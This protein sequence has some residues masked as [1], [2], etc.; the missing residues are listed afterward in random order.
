MISGLILQIIQT[1]AIIST[2]AI[3]LSL[4]LDTS[5]KELTFF[6]ER[7]WLFFRSLLSVVVIVP[8]IVMLVIF[9]VDPERAT[10][11][12]L[13]IL[14]AS[15]AAPRVLSRIIK[16]GGKHEYAISLHLLLAL[17]AI[18]TTPVTL[19]ILNTILDLGF[20]VSPLAVADQVGLSIL[21]PVIIG[22][23]FRSFFPD[24]ARRIIRPLAALSQIILFMVIIIIMSFSYDL[25]FKMDI[26]S[27]AAMAMMIIAA[28]ATGHLL[29]TGGP[30]E[31][32]TLALES[33]TRNP[34]LAL[35][36]ASVNAPLE[37]ALPVL[38]PY[39]VVFIIVT[40]AYLKYC[41]KSK[42]EHM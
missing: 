23:I 38:I 33:A 40:S 6:K 11:I 18:V 35:L 28:L 29:A 36:I 14:A 27:Y 3:M 37:R 22:I 15:P 20:M 34:G 30:E 21:V 5:F 32:T 4:G 2:F 26:R 42:K 31:R 13:V 17:L 25:I 24:A 12:G 39:L 10:A 7:P 19:T 8:I 16:S 9:L 41:T 1:G